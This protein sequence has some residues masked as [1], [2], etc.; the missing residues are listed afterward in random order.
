MTTDQLLLQ[1]RL[2]SKKM[3]PQLALEK[4]LPLFEGN[5][6]L[7]EQFLEQLAHEADFLTYLTP[8][9]LVNTLTGLLEPQHGQTFYLTTIE[10]GSFLIAAND[11]ANITQQDEPQPISTPLKLYAQSSTPLADFALNLAKLHQ[12]TF[13]QQIPVETDFIV[14]N[15]LEHWEHIPIEQFHGKVTLIIPDKWLFENKTKNQRK[16]V[17]NYFNYRFLLRLPEGTFHGKDCSA[18][19]LF[20][21]NKNSLTTQ[22]QFY[23]YDLRTGI[24]WLENT[25]HLA[26]YLSSFHLVYG[27]PKK[28]EEKDQ[29]LKLVS[30]QYLQHDW[31]YWW[32]NESALTNKLSSSKSRFFQNALNDLYLLDK[33]LKI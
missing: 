20:L 12:I 32:L 15:Y 16:E 11:Y 2:F 33:L 19:V 14:G 24:S 8:L 18:N 13:S 17:L 29:R 6:N 7:F 25:K 1:W 10:T 27:N 21:E 3:P 9:P 31:D 22:D 4:L 23:F 30:S 28:F 26:S 5:F